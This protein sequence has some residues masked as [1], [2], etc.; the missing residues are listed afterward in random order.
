V[1]V[2]FKVHKLNRVIDGT[3]ICPIHPYENFS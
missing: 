3:S 2:V 1:V